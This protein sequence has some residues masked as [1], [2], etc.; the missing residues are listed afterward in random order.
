MPRYIWAALLLR[1]LL[2]GLVKPAQETLNVPKGRL[3]QQ[4]TV[5]LA[6]RPSDR[7][8]VRPIVRPS[9]WPYDRPSVCQIGATRSGEMS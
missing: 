3:R 1:R 2:L 5:R 8:S 9:D 4:A 6:V 7:R